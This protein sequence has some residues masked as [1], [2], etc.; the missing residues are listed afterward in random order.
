[1]WCDWSSSFWSIF[2]VRSE[3]I[4]HDCEEFQGL[5]MLLSSQLCVKWD[6]FRDMTLVWRMGNRGSRHQT[7]NLDDKH[8]GSVLGK[9]QQ[10]LEQTTVSFAVSRISCRKTYSRIRDE[11]GFCH[12][13]VFS[14]I[15][16][17]NE[18][19][20]R[21][22]DKAIQCLLTALFMMLSFLLLL[23]CCWEMACRC[24]MWSL[25]SLAC[26]C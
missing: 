24:K 16:Q 19:S 10:Q 26:P 15:Q 8:C 9:N 20:T 17:Q 25:F 18:K 5:L 22:V 11:V 7:A 14:T 13:T 23:N 4:L 3:I 21:H 1:M 12:Q 2:S 6:T